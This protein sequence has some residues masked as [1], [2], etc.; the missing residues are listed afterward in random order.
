[1][2]G[3]AR[4]QSEHEEENSVD[5]ALKTFNHRREKKGR[6]RCWGWFKI[7]ETLENLNSNDKNLGGH[8]GA[9]GSAKRGLVLKEAGEGTQGLGKKKRKCERV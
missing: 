4:L 5:N 3:E 9:E 2:E 8:R 6:G 7:K 1:M